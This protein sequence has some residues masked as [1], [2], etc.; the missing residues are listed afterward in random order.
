MP[1]FSS[2]MLKRSFDVIVAISEQALTHWS[3]LPQIDVRTE[4]TKAS[5][6]PPISLSRFLAFSLHSF[7]AD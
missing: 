1:A 4:M 2:S 7:R 6:P 3:A 5:I